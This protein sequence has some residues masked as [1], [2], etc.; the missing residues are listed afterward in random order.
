MAVPDAHDSVTT[1]LVTAAVG[2][3]VGGMG[4]IA[5]Y[6]LTGLREDRTK[7]LQLTIEHTSTQIREFYAPLMA[8][9]DQLASMVVT[10]PP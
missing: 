10:L 8:L 9:T 3:V 6:I 7:R 1:I 2:A 4:W 5:A